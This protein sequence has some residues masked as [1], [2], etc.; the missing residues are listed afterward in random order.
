MFRPLLVMISIIA[1]TIL[2]ATASAEKLLALMCGK[3]YFTDGEVKEVCDSDRISVPQHRKD[4]L[5]IENAY[6]S[7]QKIAQ[8]IAPESVDSVVLWNTTSPAHPHTIVYISGY[9]WCWQVDKTPSIALYAFCT[10][11]YYIGGNGG[12]WTA[13]SILC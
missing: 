2:P 3:I 11:G 7:R 10:K 6:T 12:M 4:L 8:R 13:A 9:G 5:V 1:A